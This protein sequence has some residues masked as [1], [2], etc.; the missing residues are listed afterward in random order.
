M[1]HLHHLDI[2]QKTLVR[3][4]L[5][6]YAN[7]MGGKNSFLK[8]LETIRHAS[9]NALVSKTANIRF[10]NGIIR[11]NKT[12]H[13]DTLALLNTRLNIRT[14]ENT[15][16]MATSTDKSYKNVANMLKTLSPLGFVVTMDKETDGS[17]FG[18]KAFDIIDDNTTVMNPIFETIFFCPVAVV[19][20][21][22]NFTPKETPTEETDA[23]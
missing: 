22:L 2:I 6:A 9:P 3:E 14:K 13:R 15:N 16:L 17:G 1:C 23:H 10:S 19:K 7:A 5:L 4:Q 18:F 20:K 12:I 11:W 21:F 8:L